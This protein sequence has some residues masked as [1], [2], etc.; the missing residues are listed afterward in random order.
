VVLDPIPVVF[1]LAGT[2]E[3][4][5][6]PHHSLPSSCDP[7]PAG[8]WSPQL[9]TVTRTLGLRFINLSD[10]IP[11][12]E[13]ICQNLIRNA[14]QIWRNEAACLL[15]IDIATP[16]GTPIPGLFD[17]SPADKAAFHDT[18][19]I[20]EFV[21]PTLG[22]NHINC[23]EVYLVN[24]L[25]NRRG[26][27]ISHDCGQASAFCILSLEAARQNPLLLAHEL[28]HVL[29]LA[30]V[31]GF[32]GILPGSPGSVMEAGM[33]NP[34]VNTL[35]N[36]RVLTDRPNPADPPHPVALNPIVSNTTTPDSFRPD[37]LT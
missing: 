1:Q 2:G 4:Q 8:I 30:H 12:V 32:G 11:D 16:P 26:G 34:S 21:L 33:P 22:F 31:N 24:K 9:A 15:Q 20:Q 23:V 28:G 19:Q 3:P 13:A 27:G 10:Q 5:K 17:T 36:C 18:I 35:F 37:R 6:E 25:L 7:P 14:C 29:G